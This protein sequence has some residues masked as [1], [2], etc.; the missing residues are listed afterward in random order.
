MFRPAR[1]LLMT[2]LAITGLGFGLTNSAEAAPRGGSGGRTASSYRSG[3]NLGY[4]RHGYRHHGH[5]HYYGHGYRHGYRHHNY[6]YRWNNYR[7]YWNRYYGHRYHW[8]RYYGHRYHWNRY[9]SWWRSY[10]SG[11]YGYV[12]PVETGVAPVRTAAVVEPEV[13]DEPAGPPEPSFEAE[14]PV[15]RPAARSKT[16]IIQS[17]NVVKPKVVK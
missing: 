14:P 9:P 8:N 2:A 10:R 13:V 12:A 16:T 17:V 7:S 15:A 1:L 3:R 4:R 6:S 11:D 5:H